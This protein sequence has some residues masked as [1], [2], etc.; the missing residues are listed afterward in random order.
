MEIF[1]FGEYIGVVIKDG[2]FEIPEDAFQHCAAASCA[3]AGG[4]LPHAPGNAVFPGS[5]T[6]HSFLS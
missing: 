4:G 6:V 3:A 2:N 1:F 5:S